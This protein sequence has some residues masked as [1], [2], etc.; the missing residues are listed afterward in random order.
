MARSDDHNPRFTLDSNILVY[1]ADRAA[2]DRHAAAIQIM[3]L[4]AQA[5]ALLTFQSLS[6][7][8]SV[9]T[10]KG[11]I[12][13]ARAAALIDSWLTLFPCIAVSANAIRAALSDVGAGRAAYWDAL[14]IA[15]AAE[16][17]CT[18]I[19]TEDLQDGAA[20]RGVEI[21]NPFA[22]GGGLTGRARQ[23]LAL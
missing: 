18:L 14:L 10:R 15:T 3:A 20:L 13:H 17:G 6:E 16:A 2:G 21:H 11:M 12:E 5:G 23:L 7:F 22:R 19:L 8:Y 1:S 4:S 9:S